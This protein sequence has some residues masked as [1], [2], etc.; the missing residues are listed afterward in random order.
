MSAVDIQPQGRQMSLSPLHWRRAWLS[1]DSNERIIALASSYLGGL[2]LSGIF[3]LVLAATTKMSMAALGL[4]AVSLGLMAVLPAH[5]FAILMVSSLAYVGL[6]PFR[7]EGWSDLVSTKASALPSVIGSQGLT[8]LSVVIVIA[9][10]ALFMGLVKSGLGGRLTKRPLVAQM[11]LW[12]SLL[13]IAMAVPA[14]SVASAVLWPIVGVWISCFWILAYSVAD[15]RG[16]DATPLTLRALF[17]RPFWGGS[18]APIGKSFGYLNRFKAN[19]DR[20]LAVTRLKA[21]KLAVWAL[22]LTG[23]LTVAQWAAYEQAG[24]VPLHNAIIAH[25]TGAALPGVVN[26]GSLLV[27]YFIDLLI[28]SVWGHLIVAVVR[29]SGY[30][31]PRNTVNPLASRSLSEFWNRYF[32]YFKELLVDFFFYPAFARYFKK[33]TKVRIAFATFCAAGVGNFMYHFMRETYVFAE[34]DLI[35]NLAIFQSAVFYSLVLAIGLVISQWRGRKFAREDGFLAYHVWPRM[36]VI[37]FFCFLKIFDD[38]SGEGTL[39]E[40]ADFALSLFGV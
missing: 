7:I 16:K 9:I 23:I 25:A 3:V 39:V 27:N 1:I 31:I 22:V 32:Y 2:I 19:D 34:G 36:N 26:W 4:I 37:A 29:M 38:I 30:C 18:A 24:L 10:A 40:R 6:R 33:N 5:R 11:V 28:I 14:G 35:A 13:A 21:L 17:L 8:A 20:E 15:M 12:F